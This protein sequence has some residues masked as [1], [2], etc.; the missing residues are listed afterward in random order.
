MLPKKGEP[1]YEK[2][3]HYMLDYR[4]RNYRHFNLL[5]SVRNERDLKILEALKAVPANQKS[6]FLKTAI[7]EKL[8]RDSAK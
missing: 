8:A 5:L 4:K 1:G 3:Y 6:E 7:E 2:R